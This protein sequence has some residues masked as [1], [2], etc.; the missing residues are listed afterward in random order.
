MYEINNII[1]IIIKIYHDIG[2]VTVEG[3]VMLY[4][5][6]MMPYYQNERI[7]CHCGDCNETCQE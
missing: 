1:I 6:H 7:T 5:V 3:N 4:L 2:I